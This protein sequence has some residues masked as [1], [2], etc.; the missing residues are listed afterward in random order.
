MVKTA[1]EFADKDKSRKE[2]AEARNQA[3]HFI[4][5]T[6]KSMRELGDKVSE[7]DRKKVGEG[8]E[9]LKKAKEGEDTTAIR[10]AMEEVEKAS[11]HFADEMYKAAKSRT[12]QAAPDAETDEKPAK[13]KGKDGE[14]VIGAEFETK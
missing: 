5:I 8:L 2:V 1:E 11:H 14:D 10:K 3:D 7:A 13:K 4:H 9:A 6:E 12:D